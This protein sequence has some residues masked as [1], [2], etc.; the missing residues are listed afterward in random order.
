MTTLDPLRHASNS[1]P[2]PAPAQRKPRPPKK[3]TTCQRCGLTRH[4]MYRHVCP[5]DP[6]IVAWLAAHLPDPRD[7][8]RIISSFEYQK[9]DNPPISY[10]AIG[11]AYGSWVGLAARYGLK[12]R[13]PQPGEAPE[14]DT[15]SRNEL[16]RLADVLHGGAFG[17]SFSEHVMYAENAPLLASGLEK[18]FGG[19][20]N[21]LEAAGLRHGTRSEYY[22]AA[23]ARRRANQVPQNARR[24]LD[25][26]DE[27][28]SREYTGIPVMP[29]PRR[30]ASGGVA[31][32]VR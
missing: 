22:C 7:P 25:R 21:V 2:T 16:H 13:R 27:P 18:R 29:E 19:W 9:I 6:A 32:T 30:L 15:A 11:T 12:L 1:E 17:P 3:P 20:R 10:N 14:L 23:N 4:N 5:E 31:W 28:I 26:G 24:S 8:E